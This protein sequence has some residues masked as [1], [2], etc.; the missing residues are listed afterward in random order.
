MSPEKRRNWPDL[1]RLEAGLEPFVALGG[2]SVGEG[3]KLPPPRAGLEAVVTDRF[4]G[5][6][7]LVRGHRPRAGR[8]RLT[9]RLSGEAVGLKLVTDRDLVA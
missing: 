6:D 1:S 9:P 7:R 8:R 3:V 4:G 2:S 5:A